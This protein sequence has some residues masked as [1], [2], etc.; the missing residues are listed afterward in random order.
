MPILVW[1]GNVLHDVHVISPGKFYKGSVIPIDCFYD[2]WN[3]SVLT[4][5]EILNATKRKDAMNEQGSLKVIDGSKEEV[6]IEWID[7]YPET[8]KGLRGDSTRY[9]SQPYEK[10]VDSL[11]FSIVHGFMIDQAHFTLEIEDEFD[12][13]KL[14]FDR[15][16]SQ[17]LYDGKEFTLIPEKEW[18][19]FSY[20]E[21]TET[22]KRVEGEL[23]NGRRA[24]YLFMNQEGQEYFHSRYVHAYKK[25]KNDDWAKPIK[26]DGF[27]SWYSKVTEK[28]ILPNYGYEETILPGS[29]KYKEVIREDTTFQKYF[30]ERLWYNYESGETEMKLF[31]PLN[32][33]LHGEHVG[34]R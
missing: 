14:T 33:D 34:K 9:W 12:Q 19:T 18:E 23:T 1:Q 27:M 25:K 29:K 17:V 31:N 30:H 2:F 16:I 21:D 7:L 20:G 32:P 4:N 8:Y 26:I 10:E 5:P 28:E 6:A 13:S 3:I 24:T 11:D 15:E 22:T